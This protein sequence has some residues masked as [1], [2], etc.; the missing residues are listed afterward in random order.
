[1]RDP[2]GV[3]LLLFARALMPIPASARGPA[4]SRILQEVEEADQHLRLLNRCHP[5]FGDGSLM[6]RCL[7]L[8]PPAEPL[9]S[10]KE[11]LSCLIVACQSMQLHSRT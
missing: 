2:S 8:S 9:G 1:M 10:D 11:F 5:A 4:A 6:A 7:L 3:E